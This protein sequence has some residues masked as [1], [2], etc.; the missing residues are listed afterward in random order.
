MSSEYYNRTGSGK[1][2]ED[3]IQINRLR[4]KLKTYIVAFY[5]RR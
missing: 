2:D 5:F 1:K 4:T 3:Y